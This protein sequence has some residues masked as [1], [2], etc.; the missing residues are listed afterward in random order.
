MFA[1]PW[2][3]GGSLWCHMVSLWIHLVSL[4]LAFG[5]TLVSLFSHYFNWFPL[6]LLDFTLAHEGK[7]KAVETKR[8]KATAAK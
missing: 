4:A 1:L 7:H 2:L 6:V 8:E 5:F 3:H